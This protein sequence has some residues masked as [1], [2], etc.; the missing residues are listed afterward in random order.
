MTNDEVIVMAEQSDIAFC[1]TPTQRAAILRFFNAVAE[2][3][4][5]EARVSAIYDVSVAREACA[6]VCEGIGA[7]AHG[8]GREDSEAYDCADAIRAM[9]VV[10]SLVAR[11]RDGYLM[12]LDEMQTL[13]DA[14]AA[15]DGAPETRDLVERGHAAII[16]ALGADVGLI[17]A[18]DSACND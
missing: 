15:L 18:E 2:R 12:T 16:R 3:A 7:L 10:G 5:A 6:Q 9:S 8:P 1:Q 17:Y 14:V 4:V 13:A 11:E